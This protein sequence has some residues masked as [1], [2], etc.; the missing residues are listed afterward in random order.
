MSW[1]G[2]VTRGHLSVFAAGVENG[3]SLIGIQCEETSLGVS[4]SA[5]VLTPD[6]AIVF[7]REILSRAAPKAAT[8]KLLLRELLALENK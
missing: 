3:V 6:Q 8:R 2:T 4:R 7:V 5:V 1:T